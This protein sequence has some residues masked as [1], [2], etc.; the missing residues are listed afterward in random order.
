[1]SDPQAIDHPGAEVVHL[2]EQP[3][4]AAALAPVMETL[5]LPSPAEFAALK[6]MSEQLAMSN[7]VPRTLWGKPADVFLILLTGRDLGIGATMALQ[8]VNV[9]EGKPSIAAELMVALILRAGYRIW[10]D[11]SNDATKATAH[12]IRDGQELSAT[13]TREEATKAQLVNKDNWKKYPKA[14]LWARAVS[15]LARQSFPDVLMGV[16][17]TPD[18]LGADIDPETGEIVGQPYAPTSMDTPDDRARSAGWAGLADYERH[19]AEIVDGVALLTEDDKAALKLWMAEHGIPSSGWSKDQW[20]ALSAELAQRLH[21]E[22]EVVE[23]PISGGP[24]GQPVVVLPSE[25]AL[26]AAVTAEE[27]AR[28]DEARQKRS[29]EAAIRLAR[30]TGQPVAPE[31]A[32]RQARRLAV[33]REALAAAKEALSAPAAP[34]GPLV[35]E[36][37]D[38]VAVARASEFLVGRG[39]LALEEMSVEALSELADAMGL[40]PI[41]TEAELTA[42]IAR[43]ICEGLDDAAEMKAANPS[44]WPPDEE[45]F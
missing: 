25:D 11:P 36:R 12:A 45:P 17:Y 16:S 20:R 15:A 19:K 33:A 3:R 4:E 26:S 29:D 5:G 22:A 13:F 35:A 2:P 9:I 28:Q 38:H 43:S 1:V 14:M 31:I 10:P 32:E 21:P 41:G 39:D 8:R 6:G 30:R 18:E 23:D 27:V 40:E 24:V 34:G 37:E 7:L 42:R 44:D